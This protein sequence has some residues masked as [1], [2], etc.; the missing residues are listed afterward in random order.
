MKGQKKSSP[1]SLFRSKFG[2]VWPEN[3]AQRL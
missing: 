1:G 3:G 2:E